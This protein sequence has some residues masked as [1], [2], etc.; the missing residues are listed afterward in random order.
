MLERRA[1]TETRTVLLQDTM[2]Y[3]E[4]EEDEGEDEDEDE[5][6]DEEGTTRDRRGGVGLT[7]DDESSPAL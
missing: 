7:A 6:E 2:R 4:D 5:D 1:E 3:E